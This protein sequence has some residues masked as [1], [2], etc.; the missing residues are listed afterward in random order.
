MTHKTASQ[1]RTEAEELFIRALDSVDAY[2]KTK[3]SLKLR[4]KSLS[5]CDV[6]GRRVELDLKRFKRILVLGFGKAAASMARGIEEIL[7]DRISGGVIIVNSARDVTLKRIEIV[8]AG[9]PLPDARS[10]KGT[11]R[12]VQLARNAGAQDLVICLISGGGSALCSLPCEGIELSALRQLTGQLM[13]CGASIVEIN[14]VRKHL[15]QTKGGQLARLVYPGTLL[16]LIIS[17]VVGDRMDVIASGPTAPDPTTFQDAQ[18][19]LEKYGVLEKAS[20]SIR[21]HLKQGIEGQIRETP[22]RGEQELQNTTNLIIA[23]NLTALRTIAKEARKRGYNSFILSSMIEGDTRLAAQ[24]FS[25]MIRELAARTSARK[26]LCITAGGEMTVKV[27][28]PGKGGRNTDFCLALASMIEGMENVVILSAGTDG[29]DGAT[30]AA[31]AMIDGATSMRAA[32][33]GLDIDIALAENDSYT[34]LNKL[35]TLLVTGPTGTN[36]MDIQMV[37]IG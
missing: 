1:M 8:E 28:G 10:I 3:H 2:R 11:G 35:D 21:Q 4:G 15:S 27:H 5:A 33:Q 24:V 20:V 31:G 12:I 17:D 37:L 30:D 22:K 32:E 34:L 16:T 25:N 13:N 14:A 9:H 6:L 7:H 18:R 29:I 23:H 36:V 26:P 19:V